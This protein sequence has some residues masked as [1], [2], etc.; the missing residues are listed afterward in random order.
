M[1]G[2]QA[3]FTCSYCLRS[4]PGSEKSDEHIWPQSLGGDPLGAPW[5][6]MNVCQRCNSLAGQ[7]VDAAFVKSMIGLFERASGVEEYLDPTAPEK[8][9]VPYVHMGTAD[10]EELKEDEVA[11]IWVG[12]AGSVVIHI[13]PKHDDVWNTYAGGKPTRKR[14]ESGHAYLGFRS[15]DPFWA[16]ATFWSFQRQFK[17]AYRTL[18]NAD[19]PK[20]E[21]ALTPLDANDPEQARH[22]RIARSFDGGV[23]AQAV[24]SIDNGSRLLA[25]VALG[26]GRETLG[27]GYLETPY[28]QHLS[29]A[30]WTRDLDERAKIPVRGASFNATGG[31]PLAQAPIAWP[32]GWLLL[33]MLSD[34][35]PSLTVF[36]P[37]GKVAAILVSDSVI[38]DGQHPHW[39]RDG[40]VFLVIPAI[41]ETAGPIS[42]P[43]YL[44]FVLD[45]LD[46][47]TLK[48]LKARRRDSS[49]LP[50]KHEA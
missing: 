30:L 12:P 24:I 16:G 46:H 48:S 26:L 34:G 36:S 11:D 4:K 29:K 1:K 8:T 14:S 43:D 33:L 6:T 41:N 31:S 21:P 47:P 35:R 20:V 28:A 37:S 32:G 38:S 3:D 15:G 25:K 23:K 42:L 5:R 7:F 44:A 22:V 27:D 19:T 40:E 49:T 9:V 18:L 10:H 13:R 17:T 50:P 39:S 45:E 2:A